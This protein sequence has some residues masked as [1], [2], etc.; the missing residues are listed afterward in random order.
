[1]M[2]TVDTIPVALVSRVILAD[3]S[4]LDSQPGQRAE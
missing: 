3:W 2:A 4:N 1:M